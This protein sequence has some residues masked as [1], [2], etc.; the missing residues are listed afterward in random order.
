MAL[1]FIQWEKYIQG[2]PD[3][4]L[5]QEFK[6]PGSTVSGESAPPQN[7]ILGEMGNRNDA[8]AAEEAAESQQTM[9]NGTIGEQQ[10]NEFT[11]GRRPVGGPGG[12]PPLGSGV[13]LLVVVLRWVVPQ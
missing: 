12:G 11:E 3:E 13:L 4:R 6:N 9:P 7:L 5:A 10:Y 1:S 2:F 8:R